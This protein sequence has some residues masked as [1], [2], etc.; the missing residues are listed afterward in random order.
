MAD[1]I[2]VYPDSEYDA[3]YI[4]RNSD[5]NAILANDVYTAYS[6]VRVKKSG[7]AGSMLTPTEG[8]NAGVLAKNQADLTIYDS[9]ITTD[10]R[11]APAVFSKDI[12]TIVKLYRSSI[13][14]TGEESPAVT[15]YGG[16]IESYN[17]D[18]ITSG[19]NSPAIRI[20]S[21]GTS[22]V[23]GGNVISKGQYSPIAELRGDLILLNVDNLTS[24]M[25]NGVE[26]LGDN[27]VLNSQESTFNVNVS[28]Y[29]PEEAVATDHSEDFAAVKIGNT[30]SGI[31]GTFI[32]NLGAIN[33]ARPEYTT[34]FKVIDANATI[35]LT[36][37][38]INNA[39]NSKLIVVKNSR[40]SGVSDV[41]A[42][43]INQTLRGLI[44]V[45][46]YSKLDLA[47]N[48]SSGF[49]GRINGD[50]Q[51]GEVNVTLTSSFWSLT[52]DSYI[53]KLIIDDR[54]TISTNG[55]TLWVSG[56][57][58][59]PEGE[60]GGE[61]GGGDIEYTETFENE[62]D[63]ENACSF[64]SESGILSTVRVIKSGNSNELD[65]NEYGT[66]AAVLCND[67]NVTI[68][69]NT[70]ITTEGKGSPGVVSYN[71]SFTT[72]N[73]TLIETIGDNSS[74][75][76]SSHDGR[77]SL[78][79]VTARTTGEKSHVLNVAPLS[80]SFT[81][82]SGTYIAEGENSVVLYVDKENAGTV[83]IANAYFR[84][85]DNGIIV[86]GPQPS[87]VSLSNV[88]VSVSNSALI[89][90]DENND[91]NNIIINASNTS[92]SGSGEKG[93]IRIDSA[94]ATI[95]LSNCNIYSTD[96][97]IEVVNGSVLY[98]NISGGY[99][100]GNIV[101]DYNSMIYINLM[102]DANLVGAI[103][104]N[105]IAEK[106]N[107]V[108]RDGHW[109]VLFDSYVSLLDIDKY[110]SINIGDHVIY[111]D[112]VASE[113]IVGSVVHYMSEDGLIAEEDVV[114]IEKSTYGEITYFT[115]YD[116]DDRITYNEVT[117]DRIVFTG[118]I[119]DIEPILQMI[120]EMARDES[121]GQ[122]DSGDTVVVA[123]SDR[124][125]LVVDNTTIDLH[126]VHFK[127][128][129]DS[130]LNND[131]VN[132][133]ILV[134]NEGDLTL[135]DSDIESKGT[136]ANGIVSIGEGS[137]VR[138]DNVQITTESYHASA[139]VALD[140]GVIEG[141]NLALK[142]IGP[143]SYGLRIEGDGFI[144]LQQSSIEVTGSGS[145]AVIV[146]DSDLTLRG[147]TITHDKSIA[148]IDISGECN[149]I[150]SGGN[151]SDNSS[152]IATGG[153]YI[154]NERSND[155]VYPDG[156]DED[157]NPPHDP[158]VDPTPPGPTPPDPDVYVRR[159]AYH[160]TVDTD[161][162]DQIFTNS[163]DSIENPYA[164]KDEIVIWV[165][166]DALVTLNQGTVTRSNDQST[167]GNNAR[168]YGVGACILVTNGGLDITDT[169]IRTL[170]VGGNA[171]F[172]YNELSTINVS[173]S[174]ISTSYDESSGLHVA[175][176]GTINSLNNTVVVGTGISEKSSAIRV[177]KG[178]GTITANG[179]DYNTY[180]PKS[181]AIFCTKG[182]VE[183]S[184]AQI[185]A[186]SSELVSIE[187]SGTVSLD[188]VVAAF[189]NSESEDGYDY[190][191]C[192]YQ[193]TNLITASGKCVFDCSNS[194]I[195]SRNGGLFYVTNI[196]AEINMSRT[197]V[198][199][200]NI[201]DFLLRCTGNSNV[202][203]WGAGRN[204]G[205]KCTLN[206]S[207]QILNG[208]IYWDSISEVIININDNSELTTC[209]IDDETNNGGAIGGNG[210]CDVNIDNSSRLIV[211]GNCR[212]RH[213]VNSGDSLIRD[214]F[215]KVVT[216]VNYNNT[217]II[218]GDSDFLISVSTYSGLTEE[219]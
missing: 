205:G 26:I 61:E 23:R 120:D 160:Y 69:N 182:N 72:V 34:V 213:I 108:M 93:T 151:I 130:K 141:N 83:N 60:G 94:E 65:A 6:K 194:V 216:V 110:S 46:A 4:S 132:T 214:I 206:M 3:V 126:D 53:S 38:K 14:T 161:L 191:I 91:H 156:Y 210:F 192:M 181:P 175:E 1:L 87:P 172:A 95:N 24:D 89:V 77:L 184:N 13:N 169:V 164:S 68:A 196:E 55:Y 146:E 152:E 144:S 187:G 143:N 76:A 111:V 158:D 10:A 171:I 163:V 188:N 47:L 124:N 121:E 8:V 22:T 173:D 45:D 82:N 63:N 58:Y 16:S 56:Q 32:G 71:G 67:A 180:G 11:Y 217:L 167:G 88:S 166:A 203:D 103:D 86:S 101:A 27:T 165:S 211:N 186:A 92:F 212:L 174:N 99:I 19:P 49:T 185:I 168:F 51:N 44:Y 198:S 136:Y 116:T 177:D 193:A 131:R 7:N 129:G 190:G 178:G 119:I 40:G 62:N 30:Y 117:S 18:L 66:N 189:N 73:D 17:N 57:K 85:N 52:G 104:H 21:T 122:I 112:G 207:N 33:I 50:G 123:S 28:G 137:I 138:A 64:T 133:T 105:Q 140:K 201:Y 74:A 219:T 215:G 149:I 125:A 106:V 75:A 79:K 78:Y 142:T 157:D 41:K 36:N 25:S 100:S 43:C 134:I 113:F 39:N 155:P 200:L 20:N 128:S 37:I 195:T 139:A 202:K 170:A 147:V 199:T 54:S 90:E 153:L 209:I 179:G 204:N 127:K 197:N 159:G 183:V 5:T 118:K 145:N 70:Y 148:P 176:G 2:P 107:L 42:T 114:I 97:A 12:E 9:Y 80:N 84:S 96:K 150:I 115:L 109:V 29:Y 48:A 31:S 162:V 208:D 154:H 15:A 81:V 98:L 218:D 102:E 59:I 35:N 135:K